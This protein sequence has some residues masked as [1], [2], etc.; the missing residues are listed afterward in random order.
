MKILIDTNVFLDFL[1]AREPYHK[2]AAKLIQR[3]GKKEFEGYI[4]AHSIP[5]LFY[6]LRKQFDV[7]TRKKLLKALCET[8]NVVGIDKTNLCDAL[9]NEEWNDF[10]DCLQYLC[11]KDAEVDYIITRNPKDFVNSDIPL[12]SADEF[13]ALDEQ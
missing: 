13:L 3:C 7:P 9:D 10:E 2:S 12:L 4:A 5:N 1:Q 8:L 6:I 11:A